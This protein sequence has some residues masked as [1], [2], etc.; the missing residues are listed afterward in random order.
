MAE[1]DVFIA[2]AKIETAWEISHL[3][4]EFVHPYPLEEYYHRL[5]GKH[6]CLVAWQDKRPIGFKVGYTWDAQTFYSWMGAVIPECRNQGV[7][8]ALTAYQERWAKEEGFKF[9]RLK[10][11]NIHKRML[12][13]ALSSGYD[14]VDFEPRDSL[15]QHRIMLQ[16]LL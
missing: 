16:K 5:V 4:P 2:P 10:T 15:P 8:R 6:L 12:I 14:V 13:F 9:I 11:R 3:I 7:F 1:Q